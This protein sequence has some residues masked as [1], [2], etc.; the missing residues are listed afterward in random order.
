MPDRD[1]QINVMVDVSPSQPHDGTSLA[2][3]LCALLQAVGRP[4]WTMARLQGVMGHAFRFEMVEDG[5]D[6]MH[7]NLDWGSALE[8]LPGLA[9][10]QTFMTN[11]NDT[12]VDLP[13]VRKQ[14]RDAVCAGLERGAP[15][16]VW[17]PMD[18][19]MK[20]NNQWAVCWG[21]FV[22]YNTAEKTYTVRHPF[23]SGTY[24]I[25]YD[26]LGENDPEEAIWVKVYQ[27]PSAAD[28]KATHLTALR[29]AVGIADGSVFPADDT[30]SVKRRANAFGFAAYE[31]WREVFKAEDVPVSKTH[32]HVEILM[33][34]R[35]AAAAYLRDTIEFFPQA[36]AQLETTAAHYDSEMESLNAL[37][38]L[39]DAAQK[40]KSWESEEQIRAGRVIGDALQAERSAV[41]GLEAVLAAI[42]G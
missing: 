41:A 15:A 14:V 19:E 30:H 5:R 12:N 21:L 16:L 8:S 24:T 3:S 33:A 20:S 22:G 9:E 39:C 37:H 17:S 2:S 35:L 27:G 42:D 26:T 4:Q 13:E 32:H 10:F 18:L 36:A 29:N 38:D 1:R 11:N 23:L 7:D 6:V 28:E 31:L 34:R 25:R 40:R